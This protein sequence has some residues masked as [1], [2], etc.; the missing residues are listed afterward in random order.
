MLIKDNHIRGEALLQTLTP[1]LQRIL[2]KAPKTGTI[3]ITVFMKGNR[4][5]GTVHKISDQEQGKTPE[6]TAHE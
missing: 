5:I 1:E 3:E 4:L 6:E 2:Q